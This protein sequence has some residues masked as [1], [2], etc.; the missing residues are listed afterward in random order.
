MEFKVLFNSISALLVHPEMCFLVI[1][2]WSV[3]NTEI[4][5][6]DPWIISLCSCQL[7]STYPIKHKFRLHRPDKN[8]YRIKEILPCVHGPPV[9]SLLIAS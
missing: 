7:G 9:L 3:Y 6:H 5:T 2:Y 4:Q 8:L 1:T